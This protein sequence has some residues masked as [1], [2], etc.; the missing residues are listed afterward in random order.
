M[1][2]IKSFN[3]T[4]GL[5]R[6]EIL[7]H[8]TVL[9]YFGS[10]ALSDDLKEFASSNIC[11]RHSCIWSSLRSNRMKESEVDKSEIA[12]RTPETRNSCRGDACFMFPNDNAEDKL[13]GKPVWY[14]EVWCLMQQSWCD[15]SL[16]P[17]RMICHYVN[18]REYQVGNA[19]WYSGSLNNYSPQDGN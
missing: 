19:A 3:P 12:C 5:Y 2:S 6:K 8:H 9:L 16:C 10:Q 17:Y 13:L 1:E 14:S 11:K 15:Q 18:A 7:F 4:C